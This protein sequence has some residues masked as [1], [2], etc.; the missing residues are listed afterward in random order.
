M[1]ATDTIAAVATA[2]GRGAL[3]IVRASGPAVPA[4]LRRVVGAL[5]PPRHASYR[6]FRSADG[7]LIDAGLVV[8]FPAPASFTGEDVCEFH[9]HG[10]PVLLQELLHELCRHGARPAHPGEFSERAFRNGKLDLAQAE[11]IADLIE[12]RS[13]RAAR[14]ALRTLQGEFSDRIHAIADAL[15]SARVAF[16][17]AIDFPDEISAE[18]LAASEIPRI[19]ALRKRMQTLLVTARQGA[20]LNTGANVAIVGA[21]N[22]GKSTLLNR[23]ARAE[24]AIVSALPGTTRD[25]VEVDTLIGD[26]EVRLSDTAGMRDTHDPL[27]R[28]GIR[29]ASEVMGKADLI[30]LLTDTASLVDTQTLFAALG[31]PPSAA[32]PVLVV[33]N[34]IDTY[35]HPAERTVHAEVQHVFISAKDG[36]GI[37]LLTTTLGSLLG[38]DAADENEFVARSR[39]VV[40]LEQALGELGPLDQTFATAAPELAAE[41][42]RQA[43]EA[44]RMIVGGGGSEEL[45]GEIFSRF[46]IGK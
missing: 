8:Y 10:N 29:R 42:L 19:D 12:S 26:M 17:G 41:C 40:A 43:A 44:L 7:Q 15:T 18:A 21:P 11:A 23:L 14:S 13:L 39:H 30:L 28:E 35:T 3:G 25:I 5:T 24:K 1:T 31:Q 38:V 36:D 27:E 34:K 20:R 45:L 6:Q 4:L 22:V 37:D 9:T 16:E 32:V 33:H 46:C 2:Q